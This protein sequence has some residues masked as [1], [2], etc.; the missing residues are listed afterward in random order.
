[1]CKTNND[2]GQD[3]QNWLQLWRDQEQGSFHQ[4]CVNPLLIRFWSELDLKKCH[5]VLVPLCGKSQDILWLASQGHEV[6]GIEI[7]PIAVEDFFIENGLKAK[8]RRIGNF[9]RW[10][11]DSIS[12]WCGD[13]FSLTPDLIGRIDGIFDHTALTALAPAVRGKYIEQLLSLTSGDSNILLLTVEDFAKSS[14]QASDPIDQE[15][16]NLCKGKYNVD[17]LHSEAMQQNSLH[18]GVAMESH[19]KVYKLSRWSTSQL[20]RK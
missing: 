8:K 6:I 18:N 2:S 5:R 17:L 14:R 7:S 15:L 1:M 3:N 16:N 12:I 10:R 9:I 19:A 20:E 11:A 4:S 13:F